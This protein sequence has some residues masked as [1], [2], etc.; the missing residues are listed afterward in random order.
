MYKSQAIGRLKRIRVPGPVP[1]SQIRPPPAVTIAVAIASASSAEP[2]SPATREGPW[3]NVLGDP[4]SQLGIDAGSIFRDRDWR[5]GGVAR[6]H[7]A[8]HRWC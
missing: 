1:A 7:C 4:Q 3:T 8:K 5:I 6:R 2:L